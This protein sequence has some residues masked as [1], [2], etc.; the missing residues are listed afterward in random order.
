MALDLP[1]IVV[2]VREVV[3]GPDNPPTELVPVVVSEVEN[4]CL[5]QQVKDPV[6]R[7]AQRVVPVEN[8]LRVPEAFVRKQA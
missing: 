4:A 1:L 3:T 7:A 5:H 2:D 6:E 8:V